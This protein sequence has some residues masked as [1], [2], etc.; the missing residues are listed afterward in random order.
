MKEKA[1]A[2]C[3]HLQDKTTKHSREFSASSSSTNAN[4]KDS[5]AFSRRRGTARGASQDPRNIQW[6]VSGSVSPTR[7]ILYETRYCLFL[8]TGLGTAL[9][10]T[11]PA[12]SFVRL[13]DYSRPSQPDQD[14][15]QCLEVQDCFPLCQRPASVGPQQHCRIFF[16]M[17]RLLLSRKP[18]WS[19]AVSD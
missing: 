8:A 12:D 7:P 4:D 5:V 18:L 11:L 3:H 1:F 17:L 19:E 6:F 10:P 13:F 2:E 15:C 16:L 9:L 14:V